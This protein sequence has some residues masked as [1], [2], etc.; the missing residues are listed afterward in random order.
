ML[1]SSRGIALV[2]LVFAT[3]IVAI[4]SAIAIPARHIA[5]ERDASRAAAQ[6]L[7]KRL[8][9]ARIEAL[10]RNVNVGLRFDPGADN[11]FAEYVDGDGDGI[12]QSD[13]DAGV[14]WML[15]AASPLGAHF[16]GV[17]LGIGR[18]V[19]DPSSGAVLA[20]GSDP[21]RLGSSN[22][23]SFSPSG[24]ATSGTIYLIA[25]SGPQVCI[26]VLGATGRLRV[27]W[28]DEVGGTWRQD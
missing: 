9:A 6:Y 21:I 11:P 20:G 26:R 10:K 4:I 8:S 14:D 5:R 24:S 2:D 28:F 17:S 7:V 23:L 27:L 16:A 13:I 12:L 18:D 25:D 1:M 15:V 3:A 22:V 19:P